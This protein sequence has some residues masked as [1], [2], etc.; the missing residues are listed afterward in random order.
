V[1]GGWLKYLVAALLVRCEVTRF[2][3]MFPSCVTVVV[4]MFQC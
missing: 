2:P 1:D 4:R 3:G